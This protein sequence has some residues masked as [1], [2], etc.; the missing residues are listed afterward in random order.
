MPSATF[1]VGLAP[2]GSNH[3]THAAWLGTTILGL[4]RYRDA[5]PATVLPKTFV[6]VWEMAGGS[7][8][9]SSGG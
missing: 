6:N 5:M 1:D 8:I 2:D 9:L 3:G 4:W 7:A